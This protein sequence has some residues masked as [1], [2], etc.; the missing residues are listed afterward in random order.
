[1]SLIIGDPPIIDSLGPFGPRRMQVRVP[2]VDVRDDTLAELSLVP[3]VFIEHALA[4]LGRASPLPAGDRLAALERAGRLFASDTVAGLSRDEYHRT[5]CRSTGVPVSVVRFGADEV[6]RHM[7]EMRSIVKL[8]RP[9]GAVS[10]RRD[11]RTANGSGLW[12]RRG[13]VFGVGSSGNYP[14]IH[15]GWLEALALGYRVAVRPSRQEPFTPQRL[16]M[17]LRSAGF[18][19]DHVVLLPCDHGGADALLRGSDLASVFGGDEVV[20]R[21]ADD[22]RV[23][24]QG[25]GRSKIIVSADVDWRQ[26]LDVIVESVAGGAGVGCV[27]ASGIL[28]EG[29]PRP[30]AEAL[31]NRLRSM[32]SLPPDHDDAVLP[33]HPEHRARAIEKYLR[34]VAEGAEPVLGGDGVVASLGDGSAVLRPAVHLLPDCSSR[35]LGV[36]LPFPCAWVAP[37]DRSMGVA[38]LA[39][40]LAVTALSTDESLLD[41]LADHP[42]IRSLYIGDQPTHWSRPGMPHDGYIGEFLMR[43][44]GIWTSSQTNPDGNRSTTTQARSERLEIA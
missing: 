34:K 19:D 23:F 3:P 2:V 8:A 9:A 27:N 33:V 35:T 25:P 28:V 1:M 43:S 18:G 36:E 6:A 30:L 31:A 15:A 29:D 12:V 20:A 11:T 37:W 17:A 38:P 14:G 40:S 32:P 42:T 7:S 5:V 13:S 39:N 26:H 41:E 24:T 10:D 21:Y 44:K 16:V 22:N 4:A